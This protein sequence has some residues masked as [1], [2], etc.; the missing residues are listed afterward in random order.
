M[1]PNERLSGEQVAILEKWVAMGAPDP[2]ESVASSKR[3]IDLDAER[4]QWAFQLPV[5]H[6]APGVAD[7]SWP[8]QPLD[9]FVLAALEKRKLFRPDRP[10]AVT[11]GV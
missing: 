3:V 10:A 7:V 2:R 1:P 6:P 5:K 9:F 4:K 8:K 11:R